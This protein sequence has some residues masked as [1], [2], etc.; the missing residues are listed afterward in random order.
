MIGEQ[1]RKQPK[2][3]V[4]PED[5]RPVQV[6]RNDAAERRPRNP[7]DDPGRAHIGLVAAALTRG[8]HVGDGG[9]RERHDSAASDSLQRSAGNQHRHI[10]RRSGHHG[11]RQKQA[12]RHQHHGAAPM[13]VGKLAI[14]RRHNGRR[15]QI[16]DND[17]G[18]VLEVAEV[19]PDRRQCSGDDGLIERR[20]EHCQHQPIENPAHVR[21]GQRSVLRA[22]GGLARLAAYRVH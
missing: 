21:A 20:Q 2:G 19:A 11:S 3:Y 18:K 6:L 17:P 9:L 14:E 12:D 7:G 5:H 1:G 15:Q 4:E 13:D 8:N 22:L 16:S 10:R